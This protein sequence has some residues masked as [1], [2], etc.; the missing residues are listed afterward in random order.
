MF[1]AVIDAVGTTEDMDVT[2]VDKAVLTSETT[3]F[4]L[5]MC[6][7]VD[8]DVLSVVEKRIGEIRLIWRHSEDSFFGSVLTSF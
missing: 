1:P 5:P 2:E 3:D 4:P 7:I 6:L 8:D